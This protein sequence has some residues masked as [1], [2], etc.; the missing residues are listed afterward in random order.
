MSRDGG[1]RRST[2]KLYRLSTSRG[3]RVAR[4]G[5]ERLDVHSLELDGNQHC[6]APHQTELVDV[7]HAVVEADARGVRVGSY[8]H[9][10]SLEQ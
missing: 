4:H 1:Q 3:V 6:A 7:L 10:C 5:A 9:N 2:R 8:H